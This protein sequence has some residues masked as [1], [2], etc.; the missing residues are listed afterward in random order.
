ME[1]MIHLKINGIPVEVPAGSTILQAAKYANIE[2]PS[3]C[4][5]KDIN[6]I[7]AC[8][9][10]VVEIVGRRGLVAACVYPVEE[11]MEVLTNT[12][13]VRQSRRTTIELILSS[14]RKKCLSCVRAN[15]C[16]LHNLAFDYGVDEDRF[17]GED[18]AYPIDDASPYIVRDN[19]KCIQCMRCVAAC[20]NVQSVSCI[21]P[22]QRGFNV[23]VG[24]AFD[25]SLA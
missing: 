3:L 2:I 10:C 12:P 11:G 25:K 4:Y 18:R 16:E 15:N 19:S 21:G 9:V 6:C 22:I 7:G 13:A 14:H 1:N 24:C 20:K 23:H 5:L 17:K 8:R